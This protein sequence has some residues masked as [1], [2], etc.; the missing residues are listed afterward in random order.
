MKI[1]DFI[2]DFFFPNRCPFCDNFIVWDKLVC[3]DCI[4]QIELTDNYI[5][6]DFDNNFTVCLSA[7]SYEG[8]AKRGLLNLKYHKGF[9]AAKHLLPYLIDIFKNNI[10]IDKI[11]LVTAVPMNRKRLEKTGYNHAEIIAKMVAKRLN[12]K[13][14]FKILGKNKSTDRQHDLTR[15]ERLEAVKGSYFIK[16]KFPDIK[17]KTILLCDDIITTGSTLSECSRLLL[18]AGAKKVYCA[19]LGTT[20]L[21]EE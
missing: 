3:N 4:N 10:V 20:L 1:I 7:V 19:T 2:L 18:K 12:L 14:N 21:K 11:D 16:H 9:N 17:G 8:T 5:R 6:K 13:Y 15:A